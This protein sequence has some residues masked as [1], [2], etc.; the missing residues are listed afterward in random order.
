[1]SAH[2]DPTPAIQRRS[3]D[4]TRRLVITI[5]GGALMALSGSGLAGYLSTA[6]ASVAPFYPSDAPPLN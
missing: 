1:M 3:L 2:A 6:S 5:M 4:R